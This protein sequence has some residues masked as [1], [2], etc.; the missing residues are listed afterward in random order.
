[1]DLLLY[2]GGGAAALLALGGLARSVWAINRR[3]VV[4]VDLVQELSPD[5]GRSIKDQVTDTAADV[6]DIKTTLCDLSGRFD[7]HLAEQRPE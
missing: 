7:E 5:H 4:I 3:I 1:M 6:A 2:L